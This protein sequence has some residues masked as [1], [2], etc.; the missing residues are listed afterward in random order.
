MTALRAIQPEHEPERPAGG[1]RLAWPQQLSHDPELRVSDV[2]A[3]LAHEFPA[4]TPSKLRF[5]DSNGLVS[6]ERTGAGYRQYSA[7]D[8]ER[9]R[10]VLRRQRDEYLP[11][12]AIAAQLADLDAGRVHEPVGPRAVESTQRQMTAAQLAQAA[13][14]ASETIEVLERVGLIRQS[15]P[16]RFDAADAPLAVAG[17]AYV[18]AGGDPRSLAALVRAATR[19]AGLAGDAA[20]PRRVRDDDEAAD[21][22]ERRRVDAAVAVFSAC[23]HAGIDR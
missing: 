12:S 21:A 15:G 14:V 13:G 3:Q 5:L 11:L 16:G 2:L 22:I 19:E 20:K 9:L 1:E 18:A 7:A 8:V 4:L 17:G 10:F 23:V 6:P